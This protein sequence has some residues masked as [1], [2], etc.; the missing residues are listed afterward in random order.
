MEALHAVKSLLMIRSVNTLCEGYVRCLGQ[1]G[2]R[3][4]GCDTSTDGISK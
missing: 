2:I 3:E 1:S 4:G